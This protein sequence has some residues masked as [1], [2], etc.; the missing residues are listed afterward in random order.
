MRSSIISTTADSISSGGTITGDVTIS[1]DLT[2]EGGGDFSYSEVLTGDMKITNALADAVLYIDCSYAGGDGLLVIESATGRD[3]MIRFTEADTLKWQIYNDGS[4]DKL[5]I[6][7]D[8]DT[9]VTFDQSGNVGIGTDAPPFRLTLDGSQTLGWDYIPAQ[10]ASRVW[11]IK[12][13]TEQYGDFSIITADAQDNTLD[14]VRFKIDPSGNVGIGTVS[15]DGILDVEGTDIYFHAD[16]GEE[17][18]LFQPS[19]AGGDAR[20]RMYDHAETVKIDISAGGTSYF[21]TNVG[22]GTGSPDTLLHL[23]SSTSAKPILTIENTTDDTNGAYLQFFKNAG[24]GNASDNEI[25]GN[26]SFKGLDSAD[27]GT[28]YGYIRML[29]TDVSNTTE[30]SEYRFYLTRDGTGDTLAL[31]IDPNSRISLSNNDGGANNTIFGYLA[32]EDITTNGDGNVLLGASAGRNLTTGE[33]NTVVG[34]D[35]LFYGSTETDGNVAIGKN[36][37]AGDFGTAAVNDCVAIGQDALDAVLTST[38][39]GS[40][41]IG[42]SAL[43]AITSGAGNV[44]V[45]YNAGLALTT[46]SSNT[47]LGYGALDDMVEGGNNIAIGKN[48]LGGALDD[49]ADASTHNVFVGKDAGSGAWI[50]AVSE[51]NV[52]IGNET[53]MGAMEGVTGAVAVGHAALTALT[54]GAGNTAVGYQTLDTL[55]TGT[56][57]TAVGFQAMHQVDQAAVDSDHNTAI[58]YLS[59]GGA[60]A[61]A[62]SG[63]NVAVGNSTLAGVMNGANFNTAVGYA[64]LATA[65]SG[66]NNVAVGKDSLNVLTSGSGNVAVGYTAMAEQTTGGNNT[67]IGTNAMNDTGNV[68]ASAN[69]VFIGSG[70]GNGTWVTNETNDCVAIGRTALSGALTG[71]GD[72][73]VAI[74]KSALAS[75]TS[76]AGNTAVGYQCLDATDDGAVNTAVGYGSLSANCGNGNTVLGYLAGADVTGALNTL[77]GHQAGKDTVA[78][79]SGISNICIGNNSRTSAADSTNQIVIGDDTGG[80]ANN[81]VTLGN[82]NVTDV[83]MASDSGA[84]VNAYQYHA[85]HTS[86]S[87]ASSFTGF[88]GNYVKTAG[89]SSSSVHIKGCEV[90]T[91]FNDADEEFGNLMGGIFYATC[92]T[93]NTTSGGDNIAGLEAQGKLTAGNANNIFG[94]SINSVQTN[95]TV[96][97]SVYGALVSTDVNAGTVTDTIHGISINVDVEDVNVDGNILSLKIVTDDDS[98]SGSGC[99][100]DCVATDVWSYTN[101]DYH[102]RSY[103]GVGSTYAARIS[104]AGQIDAEGT[105]NQSQSLDYAEYFESKDG[106]PIAVGT[107]VKLDGN[108]IVACSDGDT[109]IGVIRPVGSSSIVGG[110]QIFH[111]QEKYMKDDYGA[112]IWESYT[113]TKWSEEITFEEYTK[114]GKDETGGAMGGILTDSKVEG[115]EED[116]IPNKYYREHKY[117]SDRLPSGVTAPDDAETITPSNKR[118]KLNPDYNDS[119]D[120]KSREERDEWHIV[121]L[122]GQIQVTKGQPTGSWIKMKDISDTVEMYFVK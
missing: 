36:C 99:D 122:L 40:V 81:T 53:L 19:N 69:N 18:F 94:S 11:G 17:R 82:G 4:S 24:S 63:Y 35:A 46:G 15:P 28:E 27:N 25:L 92:T 72:G 52:G 113:L 7:D 50:T 51:K 116:G 109:P 103:D 71:D 90:L 33:H 114:S 42:K 86:L 111:W 78:L 48:A 54:S 29:A 61:D 118:Q 98:N 66:G 91:T 60:W 3:S 49:T 104:R 44:A 77:I 55:T 68:P 102:W 95:G 20:M 21:L 107:T 80:V 101:V 106:K 1:G 34:K 37:M 87:L 26:I 30:D 117:H 47:V 23:E 119:K 45:G 121:G 8:G 5:K 93:N 14:T 6:Q 2:V 65:T 12:T 110:G 96:D 39:S 57:N 112:T 22:I 73:T 108:K 115:N 59:M 58:G 62:V 84:T 83:Y 88:F 105:I 56:Y 16:G 67:A 32:G 74:G 10:A 13:D 9:R 89:S 97:Q 85:E 120:Y 64:A 70:C 43:S 79:T 100:G 41:A 38:A 75:L 76:G 31:K